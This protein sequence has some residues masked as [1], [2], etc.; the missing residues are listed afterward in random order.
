MTSAWE[1]VFQIRHKE[2]IPKGLNLIAL[3]GNLLFN[4]RHY[5]KSEQLRIKPGEDSCTHIDNKE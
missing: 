2:T 1:R 5:P 3:K 4:K